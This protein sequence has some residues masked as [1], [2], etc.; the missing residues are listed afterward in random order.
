MKNTLK[1]GLVLM[2]MIVAISSSSFAQKKE[3]SFKGTIVYEMKYSGN[4]LEAADFAK[5]PKEFTAKIY[6]N[7]TLTD[8]GQGVIITNGDLK[9]VSIIIDLSAY[10]MK[11][12]LIVQKQEEIEKEHKDTKIK[13]FEDSKDVLGYKTKKAEIV[14]LTGE[15]DEEKDTVKIIAYY[16]EDFGSELVNFGD[17]MFHG[18]KGIALEFELITPKYTMKATAKTIEKGKVKE[19]DFLIP[20]GCTETTMEAFQE[21]MKALQGGGDE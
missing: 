10:G 13:Y 9:K 19:T 15:D 7:T 21:E 11:K 17:Q 5:K 20:T 16:T 18:L 8:Q 1:I 4:G 2:A 12:Y 3:K 6:E 14:I